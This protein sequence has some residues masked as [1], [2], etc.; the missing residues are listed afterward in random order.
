MELVRTITEHWKE[1]CERNWI[2]DNP[3][4]IFC[5]ENK[6][7]VFLNGLGY[8]L[9]LGAMEGIETDYKKVVRGSRELPMSSCPS[10]IENTMYG[11]GSTIKKQEDA[12][13]FT[14]VLDTV[15]AKADKL[16]S[17]YKRT[18]PQK[19]KAK[20]SETRY[21]RFQKILRELGVS[22]AAF[23][24]AR[25]DTE[26]RFTYSG[27]SYCVTARQ[28]S[29]ELT[30]AGE[31]YF[32]MDRIVCVDGIHFYDMEMRDVSGFVEKDFEP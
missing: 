26:G 16:A 14:R 22:K 12:D 27:H 30:S 8:F 1:Y 24:H 3:E 19:V 20:V 10:Y 23:S 29:P 11:I 4:D 2:S 25:V 17:Y 32:A 15:D 7:K 31:E 6:V 28:Y 18:A 9:F 5:G 21:D 13:A